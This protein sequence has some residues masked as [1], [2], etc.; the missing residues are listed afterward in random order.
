MPKLRLTKTAIEKIED[1]GLY[2]DTRLPGFGVRVRGMSKSYFVQCRVKDPRKPG[3]WRQLRRNLGKVEVIG[4]DDAQESA[5]KIMEDAGAGI[6]PD[7]RRIE[8]VQAEEARQ[9]AE[10]A[11]KEKDVTLKEVYTSYCSHRKTLKPGSQAEYLTTL[12]YHVP[13]WLEMPI[14]DITPQMVLTRHAEIGKK[15]PARANNTMRIIR[16]LCN[17]AIEAYEDVIIRNPT[18]KLSTLKAWYKIE[19]KREFVRPSDLRKFWK[20]VWSLTHETPRDILLT[21]LFTGARAEEIESLKWK[22]VHFRGGFCSIRTTKS[23]RVLEIPLARYILDLLKSRKDNFY[24]G[25]DSFI[26]PGYN[27]ENH[28][29]DLR[30]QCKLIVQSVKAQEA[31]EAKASGVKAEFSGFSLTP[32]DLRRSFQSYADE[33]GIS[34]YTIKR[35]VNHALPTDV[36]EGYIQFTMERLRK[37]VETIASFI[38]R[39]AGVQETKV[40]D[41]EEQRRRREG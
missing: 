35:L 10:R 19:R 12:Q 33:C 28:Y 4:L 18:K 29:K 2:W 6:T 13:D 3:G 14:R 9:R 40:V 20:A 39:N 22:D 41:L 17:Y 31:A 36:T 21:L 1:E 5:R 37:D 38:L 7:D 34:P 25:P 32:H 24:A 27:P 8:K 16:A 11:E 23:G 30:H 15:S 26:F